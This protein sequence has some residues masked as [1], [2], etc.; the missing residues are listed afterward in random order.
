MISETTLG[1]SSRVADPSRPFIQW[2]RPTAGSLGLTSGYME[3][4]RAA[5]IFP[6]GTPWLPLDLPPESAQWGNSGYWVLRAQEGGGASG[7]G[8][9]NG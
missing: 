1:C 9:H 8:V 5:S 7:P 2:H 6:C 3:G 4:L